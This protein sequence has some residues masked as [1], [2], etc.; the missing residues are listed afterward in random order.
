MFKYF[1]TITAFIAIMT[2]IGFVTEDQQ[3][4]YVPPV[5]FH[6]EIARGNIAEATIW[7]AL[8]EN[9]SF[10]T[11]ASG[12][13]VWRGNEL[14][15]APTATDV[16]PTPPDAGEQMT[17]V[18]ES[19]SDDSPSGSG[20]QM[21][22]IDFIE[23]DGT[24]SYE[25]LVMN[26]TTGVNTTSTTIRFVNDM[27]TISAGSGGVAAGHIKIY[28]TGTVGLVYNMI[29]AGGN[30]SLVPHRMVPADKVLIVK[31]WNAS[32][33]G[34]KRITFRIRS[35]DMNGTLIPG[36]FCFKGTT[37]VKK[38]SSGDLELNVPIPELSIIKVSG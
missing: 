23:A 21:V 33:A 28:K 11:T 24:E 5:D 19:S 15:P 14:T 13:D 25:V 9:G 17:I 22:R 38:Q 4:S 3:G 26:G 31:K 36:V 27:Y 20:A 16:I 34:D 7:R 10:G 35:T 1:K 37:Y 32:E 12:E 29:A 18:S 6:A 8:G 2:L 30:K